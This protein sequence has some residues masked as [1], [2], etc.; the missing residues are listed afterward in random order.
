MK[1]NHNSKKDKLKRR[2]AE[3]DALKG[4][5]GNIGKKATSK[6]LI[7]SGSKTQLFHRPGSNK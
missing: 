2:Q 4:V 1:G 7:V 5:P 6:R 3:F